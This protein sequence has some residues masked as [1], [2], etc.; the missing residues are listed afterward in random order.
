[1]NI[2]VSE[3]KNSKT[4]NL[5]LA[6]FFSSGTLT[7]GKKFDSSR[8]KGRPFKFKLAAG[9]VIRGN[10]SSKNYLLD[11]IFDRDRRPHLVIGLP[12]FVTVNVLAILARV[13]FA[14]SKN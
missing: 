5:S 4:I 2:D 8:D 9:Q 13:L 10:S 1:M 11:S 6:R 7:N 12:S 14:F 3:S